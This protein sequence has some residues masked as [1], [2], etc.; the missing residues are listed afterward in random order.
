MNI[1][2]FSRNLDNV[3][4]KFTALVEWM[5]SRL[6]KLEM[7]R[8]F[9]LDAEIVAVKRCCHQTNNDGQGCSSSNAETILLPFQV[10]STMKRSA[11]AADELDMKRSIRNDDDDIELCIFAFD[12]IYLDGK[13]LVEHALIDRRK[14]LYQ[15]LSPIVQPGYFEFANSIDIVLNPTMDDLNSNSEAILML[16]SYLTK[17]IGPGRCEGV[18]LK[19]L[20]S[21]YKSSD[22][23]EKSGGYGGW[24]KL[25]KDYVDTI[26]DSIDVVPIGAWRGNGRKNK[27]FSPFLLAVYD[28]DSGDFQS[29][30]RCMSG[31]SDDFYK[32]KSIFYSNRLLETKSSV[33]STNENPTFWFEPCEVWEIRGAD[34]TISPVHHA[35]RGQ[36]MGSA[37]EG[38]S[39]RFPRFVRLRDDKAPED[40]TTGR[41][42]IE[43]FH[44]QSQRQNAM[45]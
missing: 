20:Y 31:F 3:T 7:I 1:L 25:K 28:P 11:V 16:E 24:R 12:I 26:A 5:K 22:T 4:V 40:A 18:M 2:F 19:S 34:L 27:W 21:K 9:I 45:K 44:S 30:C 41:Q 37:G 13:A 43:L 6:Q 42:I 38:I 39:L 23:R 17:S 36:M 10:L 33:V 14:L 35:G 15:A 8:S 32:E 29:L